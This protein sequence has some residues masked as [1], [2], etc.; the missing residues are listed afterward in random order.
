MP[1][2]FFSENFH[3]QLEASTQSHQNTR[4]SQI[5]LPTT[6]THELKTHGE[7]HLK[8]WLLHSSPHPFCSDRG[9]WIRIFRFNSPH[10]WNSS[11]LN[12][13]RC[14]KPHTCQLIP[15]KHEFRIILLLYEVLKIKRSVTS[16][17]MQRNL[18]RYTQRTNDYSQ[19]I[20]ATGNLKTLTQQNPKLHKDSY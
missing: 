8:A 16:T 2:E 20:Q 12:R 14:T 19:K 7:R 10:L 18:N 11:H 9:R 4:T 5:C 15:N 17:F 6:K 1:R 3:K 13:H